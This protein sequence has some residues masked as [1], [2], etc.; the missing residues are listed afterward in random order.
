[1][2][3]LPRAP[4]RITTGFAFSY[5]ERALKEGLANRQFG[6]AEMA[7][8]LEFFG[9]D[10]PECVYCG[11]TEVKRWDHLIP[12]SEGGETVLGNMVPACGR[13]DDSKQHYPFEEWMF[14]SARF[15]PTSRQ[16][17]DVEERIQ[18]IKAYERN[19]G[20]T[21][22]KL[23]ERLT[24]EELESLEGIRQVLASVRTAIETLIDGH[25]ARTDSK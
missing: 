21:P 1:M 2:T 10:P 12:V 23:E 8:I 19:F 18:R 3:K 7:T 14:G 11:S 25:R 5:V 24:D 13:C 15:S 4:Q 16:V 6:K 9:N 22:R 20:Y 17:P